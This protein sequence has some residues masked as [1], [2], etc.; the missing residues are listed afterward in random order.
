MTTQTQTSSP[1]RWK[2]L[3]LLCAAFFMVA[4]DGQIVILAMPS[5]QE[6]LG[7]TPAALQWVLS[8][9][10][11]GFGGLLLL[12]GRA[13]DLLGQRRLFTAG[14]AL[15]LLTSLLCGLAWTGGVLVGARVG[16]GV[17]AAVMSPTA[18]ALLM[19][20]FD[21][22][23]ERNRALAVWTGT[24]AFGAT[25]AL[26]VGGALTDLLGWEWVFLLNVPVAVVMLALTPVLLPAGRPRGPRGGFDT[27]GALTST[28]AFVLLILAVVEA[29][30]A[31]W[32]SARTLGL[33]AASAVLLAVFAAV[34]RRA[35][36]PLVPLRLFRSRAL[37]GG[38]LLMFLA[39]MILVGFNVVVS[40][41][42]QQVLLYSAVFFG[43]G[44]L[45]YALMDIAS[46][47]VGG[48]VVTRLGYRPVALAG[49]LL[50][51]L[52]CLLMTRVSPGGDY[53]GDLF[54]GLLVF[55]SGVGTCFVS[56]TIAALTGV[57]EAD[58]GVASGLN[59][60]AFWIGGALGAA[61]VTTVSVTFTDGTGPAA[62]TDGYR[63]AFAACTALAALGA[64]IAVLLPRRDDREGAQALT[65]E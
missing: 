4:L 57:D 37:T 13:A 28:L 40:L 51:G 41:Y 16:Q 12:G 63:A 52:G 21:E 43:V 65:S 31:G 5:I 49:M 9:Y 61:V 64:V 25:A 45:A 17:S 53:F 24:G 15:F 7:M 6:D 33:L 30:E 3:A 14:T 22:G 58:A 42:A 54:W 38:N 32:A 27:A 2:A 47:N 19:H 39:G 46:A 48:T 44:T 1:H 11:L 34:E 8:G 18:L 20:A 50:L 59:N 62:L 23:P 56:V 60:A 10:L 35:A 26:L 36:A 55:G 29:P